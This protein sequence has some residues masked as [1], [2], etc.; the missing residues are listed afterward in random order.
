MLERA[1]REALSLGHNYIGTEHILLGLTRENEG[2]A[3]R[4]LLD[5]DADAEKIRN[6]VIRML[7]G[8]GGL[9][10]SSSQRTHPDAAERSGE[11]APPKGTPDLSRREISPTK[12]SKT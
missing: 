4:I 9:R 1:L 11:D 8:P 6:E 2:A 10:R 5:L 12:P 7:S 3:S